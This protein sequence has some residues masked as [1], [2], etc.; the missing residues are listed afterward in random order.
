[1]KV[2]E[3]GQ[4]EVLRLLLARGA[5]V[6]A[7]VDE[8]ERWTAFHF[9]CLE[10]Q[11]DCAEA[12]ARAGCDVRLKNALGLTGWQIAERQ[13]YAVVVKRLQAL[14]AE[15]AVGGGRG[16]GGGEGKIHRVDP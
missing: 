6:D 15:Q 9:A 12:L 8:K 1:M 10:N 11:P 7:L 3:L 5:A 16:G 4:L 13:G 2:A 14:E